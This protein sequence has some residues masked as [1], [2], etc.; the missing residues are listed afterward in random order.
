MALHP[1]QNICSLSGL[2]ACTADSEMFAFQGPLNWERKCCYGSR[3]SYG[4]ILT[5][6]RATERGGKSHWNDTAGSNMAARLGKA[7]FELKIPVP[8]TT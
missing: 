7:P 2:N 5:A 8:S 6:V 1:G 4:E 3:T